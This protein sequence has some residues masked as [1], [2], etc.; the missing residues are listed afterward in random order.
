MA[1]LNDYKRHIQVLKIEQ[2]IGRIQNELETV[3]Y[4]D[5]CPFHGENDCA[6][7]RK[8]YDRG[9]ANGLYEALTLFKLIEADTPQTETKGV[10]YCNEC[11][12]FRDKQVCGRCRS[13]NLFAKAD[14]P[15]TEDEYFLELMDAVK[16]GEMSDASANQAYYEYINKQA[17][18]SDTPQTDCGWK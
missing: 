14:T 6:E 2:E 11:K 1:S 18:E 10:G 3:D 16:R 7:V 8:A 5:E 17:E 15:Q 13:K 4:G 12:W 9:Y